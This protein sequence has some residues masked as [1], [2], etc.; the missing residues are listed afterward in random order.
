MTTLYIR[1]VPDH[2]ASV[3]KERA[4]AQG[5]SLSAYVAAQLGCLTAR[6]TNPE[7]AQRLRDLDRS[8]GASREQILDAVR[9]SRR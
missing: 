5:Q 8:E 4:A 7:I 6:P 9:D 2:V 3:L 1:D